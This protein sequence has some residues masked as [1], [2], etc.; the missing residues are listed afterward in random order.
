MSNIHELLS[1]VK[2]QYLTKD[3]LEQYRDEL[4]NLYA[5][6]QFELADVRKEKAMYFYNSEEKTVAAK[7][8]SWGACPNGQ[9][10]I[11]LSHYTKGIEKVL[12][13]LK[14]RLYNVY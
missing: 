8:V 13:S 1:A 3:Q 14:S 7:Q 4:S 10:E 11:E 9:R 6:M 12:S 5:Q 2:E